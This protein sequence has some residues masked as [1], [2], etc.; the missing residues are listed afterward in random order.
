MKKTQRDVLEAEPMY[1]SDSDDAP[2][3]ISAAVSKQTALE[4]EK[5][6]NEFR[7]AT[8]LARRKLNRDR[9][10]KLKQASKARKTLNLPVDIDSKD[11]PEEEVPESA[12]TEDCLASF[13]KKKYLDPELFA[14]ASKVL[15]DSKKAAV[16]ALK[17]KTSLASDR[18]K[19]KRRS[20]P[21]DRREIGNNTSVVHISPTDHLN[22]TAR[23]K[24][25]ANFARNRIYTKA[26]RRAIVLPRATLAAKAALGGRKSPLSTIASRK[27][28]RPAL[29]FVRPSP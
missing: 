28:N 15:D 1:Q 10:A 20:I 11:Q 4:K 24:S 5:A 8:A 9:D 6:V 21:S 27:S 12:E 29:V 22:P 23:P 14:S 18:A 19:R 26:N 3:I 2:E 17:H 13:S 25:A 16:T 7:K